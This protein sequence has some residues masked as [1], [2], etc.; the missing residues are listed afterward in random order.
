MDHAYDGKTDA[1]QCVLQE[2]GFM[3]IFR[4]LGGLGGLTSTVSVSLS[5]PNVTAAHPS[6]AGV[7][8]TVLLYN[9]TLFSRVYL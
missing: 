8:I 5:V 9:G 3:T 4:H 1:V 7:P 2:K 6:T